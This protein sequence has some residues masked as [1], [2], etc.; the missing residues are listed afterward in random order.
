MPVY[1]FI[2]LSVAPLSVIPPPSAVTSDG[3]LTEPNSIFLSSTVRVTEFIVVVVP[4]M[5]RSPPTNR[6]PPIPTPPVT[7]K[8]PVIALVEAA[9]DVT[10]NPETLR[11]SVEGL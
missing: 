1:Q 11:I 3:E 4:L 8:A 5:V 6:L 10:A 7:T 2:N 9:P